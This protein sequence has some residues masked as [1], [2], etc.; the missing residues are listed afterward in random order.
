[1]PIKD[2]FLESVWK[3]DNQSNSEKM[4]KIKASFF[5]SAWRAVDQLVD[6][7]FAIKNGSPG[8]MAKTIVVLPHGEIKHII[9]NTPFGRVELIENMDGVVTGMFPEGWINLFP[10]CVGA[11]SVETQQFL[12][13]WHFVDGCSIDNIGRKLQNMLNGSKR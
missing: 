13:G 6:G 9:I 2:T 4:T 3:F 10:N 12:I 8:T 11:L 7:E 5:E 1:M